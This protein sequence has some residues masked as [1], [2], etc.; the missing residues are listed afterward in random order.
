MKE[1]RLEEIRSFIADKL[2]DIEDAVCQPNAKLTCIVRAPG[3]PEGYAI[4]TSDE[5]DG[6][7]DA[8]Q[9]AR[10]KEKEAMT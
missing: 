4:V 3:F 8:L 1:V 5:L 9:R 10:K 7:I 2:L 6:A